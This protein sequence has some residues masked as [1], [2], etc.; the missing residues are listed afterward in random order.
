[1][2]DTHDHP[3]RIVYWH[4]ELPPV[5]AE[6][7]DEHV[8]EATS[9]RVQGTLSHRDELWDRCHAQLM[10]ATRERIEQEVARLG[11]HYAHVLDESIDSRHDD[12]T[13]E[14]WLHGRFTYVLY[15]EPPAGP[16]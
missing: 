15:R 2:T 3:S 9:G 16:A 13:C 14:A 1:M 5:H 6:V 7:L 4:R 12:A 8:V 11:G 10:A